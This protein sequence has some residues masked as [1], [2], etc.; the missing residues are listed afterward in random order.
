MSTDID[1]SKLESLSCL[2]IPD[3][4]KASMI[5]GIKGVVDMLHEIDQVNIN[6]NANVLNTPTV[7]SKDEV[8]NSFSFEKDK[9]S[10]SVH[11]Q[12]GAFLAPKV[13]SK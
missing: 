10:E 11:I 6:S 13:I 4:Q 7:L 9:T 2:K 1:L 12:D 5:D 3:E 8:N